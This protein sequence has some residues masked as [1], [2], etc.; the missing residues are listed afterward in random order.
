[1]NSYMSPCGHDVWVEK[2]RS[3]FA[4]IEFITTLNDGLAFFFF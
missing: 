2:E 3:D 1:M 4:Y